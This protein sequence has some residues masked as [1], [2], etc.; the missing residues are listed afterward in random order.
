LSVEPALLAGET[1]PPPPKRGLMGRLARDGSIIFGAAVILLMALMGLTAPWLGT[2]SPSEINPAFRNRVPGIEQ[3]IRNDDG[4]TRTFTYRMGTDSLGRDVYSRVV[5][6]ARISLVIGITVAIISVTIGVFIGLVSGYIRWIDAI[7]MRLM[8]GLMAIPAI[9]LA[10]ALVSLFRAGL[11]SVI[12]AIIVPEVPRVVRLVRSIVLSVREEPYVEAAICAGTPT[13]LLLIRHILPNTIPALIV[14]GT[15]ICANAILLEA[16][17]SF[18]GIGIPPE[19]PT[20][21]NIMAE[22]R[23]LFRIYP[24]NIFF[25]GICL[26]LTVLA[27]NVLG[28]GL[29]DRLDPKLARRV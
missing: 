18:L 13:H 14:Q 20:W 23:G 21:G 24:H 25:P 22:G 27:V 19:T 5:Y 15:F 1:S 26:A 16:I 3:T 17:L 11:L 8:D 4:T 7:V 6:G 28:D 29:R 12:V 9:L 10:I 2:K